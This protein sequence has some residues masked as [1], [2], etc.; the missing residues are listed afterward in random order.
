MPRDFARAVRVHVRAEQ[1]A[2]RV[3]RG[4]VA[5][6]NWC[7]TT[8]RQERNATDEALQG[9]GLP[10]CSL[11][12]LRSVPELGRDAQFVHLVDEH[13]DVVREGGQ[14][15]TDDAQPR[16]ERRGPLVARGR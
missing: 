8:G 3:T 16:R 4:A 1:R 6:C 9:M 11:K 10:Q 13:D 12:R 7:L 5:F 14:L 15:R 2:A